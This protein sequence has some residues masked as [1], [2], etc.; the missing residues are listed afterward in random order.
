MVMLQIL[1]NG[2]EP[3]D[4]G[5]TQLSSLVCRSRGQQDDDSTINIIMHYYIYNYYF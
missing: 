2:A 1:L 3:C 5:T 4:A